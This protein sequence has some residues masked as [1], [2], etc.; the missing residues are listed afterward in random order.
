MDCPASG[1][2]DKSP[3][4]RPAFQTEGGAD[5]AKEKG[6]RQMPLPFLFP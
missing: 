1:G 5:G 6:E 3:N 2:A 4:L